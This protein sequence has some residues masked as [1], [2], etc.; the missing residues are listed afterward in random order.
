MKKFFPQRLFPVASDIKDTAF[1]AES[2]DEHLA[3]RAKQGNREAYMALYH[4]YL[5]KV[6]NR[7]QSRV[8]PEMVEDVTQE[9]FIAVL[10]SISGF[11]LEARFNTWLY[12][13]VN[14]QIAEFY[15][16]RARGNVSAISLD[17]MEGGEPAYE[18]EGLEEAAAIQKALNTIPEHY[19]DIVMMRF[20]DGLSFNEIADQRHQS[21]EAV[22]SLF[23]RAIQAIRDE[24]GEV[25]E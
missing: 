4:R 7:V 1:S 18:Y 10:R 13:I 22:K 16:Q 25:V 2:S 15:R 5:S 3:L 19:R 14:R 9:I 6:Y 17:D 20:I 12:T 11:R 8:P 24:I 21:L 23:R